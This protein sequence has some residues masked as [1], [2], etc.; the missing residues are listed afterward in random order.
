MTGFRSTAD[1]AVTADFTVTGLYVS[2][3]LLSRDPRPNRFLSRATV[4]RNFR[5]YW[6]ATAGRAGSAAS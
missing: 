6:S 4:D 1:P 5:R 2:G 3:P